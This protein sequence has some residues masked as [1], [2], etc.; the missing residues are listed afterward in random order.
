MVVVAWLPVLS[1]SR[2]HVSDVRVAPRQC[3][4]LCLC[5]ANGCTSELVVVVVAVGYMNFE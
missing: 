2:D 3:Q 1:R 5:H 4:C